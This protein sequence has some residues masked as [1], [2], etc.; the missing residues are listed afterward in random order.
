MDDPCAEAEDDTGPGQDLTNSW[1]S[2]K[3]D[4]PSK[5]AQFGCT[6]EIAMGERKN[7]HLHPL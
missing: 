5:N 6:L 3:N 4:G 2:E 1:V 7:Y